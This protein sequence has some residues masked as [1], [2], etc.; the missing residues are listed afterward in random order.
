MD[1][2]LSL[3]FHNLNILYWINLFEI[4]IAFTV[5]VAYIFIS[6]HKKIKP[7]AKE[8]IQLSSSEKVKFFFPQIM[9][10]VF[11]MFLIL[12]KTQILR[13]IMFYR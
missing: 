1:I 7:D 4:F 5:Y 6:M 9:L 13:F 3:N 8:P 11:F 10:L 2:D 12:L